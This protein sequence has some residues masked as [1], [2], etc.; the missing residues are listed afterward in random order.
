VQE[1]NSNTIN[2]QFTVSLSAAAT[3]TVKVDYRV[4]G[5]N[6]RN[7]DDFNGVTGT[8]EFAPGTQ[9]QTVIVPVRGDV[10]DEYDETFQLVLSNPLNASLIDDIGVGTIIDDDSPPN[11]SISGN[12]S[13]VEGSGGATMLSIPANLSIASGK[14]VR[15]QVATQDL[16]ATVNQ[17]YQL[18]LK[19]IFFNEGE[20]TKNILISVN[21]DYR[22][23]PNESFNVS[24]TDSV[25][26]TL[27]NSTVTATILNDDVGGVI[28]FTVSGIIIAEDGTSAQ[29]TVSRS[30]GNA[31]DVT[32]Q[33]NTMDGS[34]RAGNDY[35]SATGV[36]TF[37]A[38]ET[39]KTITV[40]IINDTLN[41][42]NETFSLNLQNATGG[43]TL[44]AQTNVVVTIQDNDPLPSLSVS[45][46][47][48]QEGNNGL[49][50][51]NF[52]VNLLAASGRNVRVN[53]RTA[54]RQRRAIT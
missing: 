26:A 3:Q 51:I 9:T 11:L 7:I 52:P 6:A 32:I 29:I 28:Q 41:E 10:S 43:G 31:S 40:P 21:P 19:N 45:N 38:N 14:K 34:A 48:T 25:D 37:G 36:L 20:T 2:A 46:F 53:Y 18:I 54:R 42:D 13:I 23:E 15:A 22:V 47:S 30:G 50:T 5:R 1:G 33:Y 8:I 39:S 24:L 16:T 49:K 4:V 12:V 27:A 17:D 35:Q 44:G